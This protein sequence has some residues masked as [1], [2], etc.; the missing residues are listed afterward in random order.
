MFS[1]SWLNNDTVHIDSLMIEDLGKLSDI[2]N[3]K[4]IDDLVMQGDLPKVVTIMT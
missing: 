1:L 2:V 4:Y 3:V